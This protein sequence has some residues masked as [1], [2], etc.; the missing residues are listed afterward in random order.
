MAQLPSKPV[1]MDP[2]FSPE[3]VQ[4]LHSLGHE[5]IDYHV[6]AAFAI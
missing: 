2:E 3:D 1:S 4:F 6:R 5:V